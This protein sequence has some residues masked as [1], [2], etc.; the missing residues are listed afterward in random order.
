MDDLSGETVARQAGDLVGTSEARPDKQ[1]GEELNACLKGTHWSRLP[2]EMQIEI[3][4]QKNLDNGDKLNL[5]CAY[6]DL[7]SVISN[8][9][10]H[11]HPDAANEGKNT[12]SD[13]P[14]IH[15]EYVLK[16]SCLELD[17]DNNDK[18]TTLNEFVESFSVLFELNKLH[19][20]SP[21]HADEDSLLSHFSKFPP[22]LCFDNV[23][24]RA[25][26]EGFLHV[27]HAAKFLRWRQ[28]NNASRVTS[29]INNAYSE[30]TVSCWTVN[31]WF[32]RFAA[33]DTS[34]QENERYERPSSID[35]NELQ[36]A[37]KANP[38]TTT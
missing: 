25:L 28:N 8:S 37:I 32:Y 2:V 3:V 16:P 26:P 30:G 10:P 38:E 18:W 34:L 9:Y 27:G 4:K 33:E 6:P 21:I 14:N 11:D 22:S 17:F 5:L 15:I 20:H 35:N 1:S 13:P 31:R 24:S 36:S 7:L 23:L 12:W 19:V 29:N